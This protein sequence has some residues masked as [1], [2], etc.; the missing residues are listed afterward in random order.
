MRGG[1]FNRAARLVG[2]LAE[3]DFESVRGRA[4][5]VDVCARTEDARALA[6]DDDC[7]HLWLLE[8]QTLNGIG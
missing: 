7:A 8:A 4:E 5:H 6:L 3:V 1:V 2:E